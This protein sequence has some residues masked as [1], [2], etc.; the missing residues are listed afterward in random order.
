MSSGSATRFRDCAARAHALAA[1]LLLWRPDEFW[2][3]T[4]AEFSMALNDPFA[5]GSGIA[6]SRELIVQMME[7]ETHG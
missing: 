5:L 6:P 2:R 1:R 3:A 7:R 4:P